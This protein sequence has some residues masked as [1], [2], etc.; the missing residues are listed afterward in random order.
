MTLTWLPSGGQGLSVTVSVFVSVTCAKRWI[1]QWVIVFSLPTDTENAAGEPPH[2]CLSCEGG[3]SDPLSI[4]GFFIILDI[5]CKIQFSPFWELGSALCRRHSG[6][7]PKTYLCPGEVL[8]WLKAPC[9]RS[10][11]NSRAHAVTMGQS[12]SKDSAWSHPGRHSLLSA[13]TF[14]ALRLPP[15]LHFI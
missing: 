12:K 5:F 7:R 9:L 3:I 15:Q 8:P 14:Q 13:A 4:P 1:V 2:A 6:C 10:E 11:H